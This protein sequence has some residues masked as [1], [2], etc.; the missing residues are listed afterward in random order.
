MREGASKAS[1]KDAAWQV[2]EQAY[3]SVSDNNQLP[4]NARQIMYVA[5]PLIMALTG[6]KFWKHSSSFTQGALPDFIMA[7]PELTKDWDVV[8]DARGHFAEP[9]THRRIGLG[10]VEVRDYVGAW[11]DCIDDQLHEIT[12][13]MSCPTHGP[14]HRYR[15]ALFVEKEGFDALLERARIEERYDLALMSTKGLSVTAARQLVEELSRRGVTILVLH[16]FDK[17]GLSI[18]HTIRTNT[19]RFRF[20]DRPNVIDLGL[21]LEDV[22]GLPAE[23]VTFPVKLR[24]DPRIGL[25]DY[26]ATKEERRFLVDPDG[27][28]WHGQRVELNALTSRQFIDFL[29]RKL[30]EHDVVK[31]IP[32]QENLTLA[33]RLA[34]RKVVMQQAINKLVRDAARQNVPIPTILAK[35]VESLLQKDAT[36]PWDDALVQIAQEEFGKEV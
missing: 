1:L 3:L 2:M 12:L 17:W 34:Y 35:R 30:T 20:W 27:P 25:K 23:E 6:G 13:N 21:R 11:Q 19:R 33:Y 7:N 9:H 18:L 15:Y 28:P 22:R 10:T 32:N 29:E 24:K 36:L 16:D 26:G 31:V 8:F 5:R 4:A 14:T